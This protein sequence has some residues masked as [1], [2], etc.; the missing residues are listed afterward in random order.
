MAKLVY[1]RR[2]ILTREKFWLLLA[3]YSGLNQDDYFF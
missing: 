1:E 2:K 3:D